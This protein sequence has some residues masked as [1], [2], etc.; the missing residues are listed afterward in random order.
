MTELQLDPPIYPPQRSAADDRSPADRTP[1]DRSIVLVETVLTPTPIAVNEAHLETILHLALRPGQQVAALYVHCIGDLSLDLATRFGVVRAIAELPDA[2]GELLQVALDH[3]HHVALRSLAAWYA[4][5]R[6]ATAALLSA[7]LA[8]D[9]PQQMAI[10]ICQALCDT[11]APQSDG[12]QTSLLRA[13]AAAA[14]DGPL[15]RAALAALAAHGTAA[16]VPALRVL[17]GG[18]AQR[19]LGSAIPADLLDRKPNDALADDRLPAAFAHSLRANLARA[20]T[21]A[22]GASNVREFLQMESTLVQEAA[23]RAL[24]AIGG[25]AAQRALFDVLEHDEA[26]LATEAAIAALGAV[27]APQGI[28]TLLSIAQLSDRVRYHALRYLGLHAD[29]ELL[30]EMLSRP[31]PHDDVVGVMLESIVGQD[32]PLLAVAN[33]VAERTRPRDVREQAIALL[34]RLAEPATEVPLLRVATDPREPA[35]LRG[36]AAAALPPQIGEQTRRTLRALARDEQPAAVRAGSLRALARAGDRPSLSMLLHACLDTQTDVARAGVAG[37]LALRDAS[38][39]PALRRLATSVQAPLIVRLEAAGALVRLGVDA[40][41]VF[42]RPFLDH[43]SGELQMLAIEQLGIAPTVELAALLADRSRPLPVRLRLIELIAR[44]QNV[45]PT[46]MKLV[47]QTDEEPRLRALALSAIEVD[48]DL[49][50]LL[51]SAAIQ[52]GPPAVRL[53]AIAAIARGDAATSMPALIAVIERAQRP[54]PM[55][56][57]ALQAFLVLERQQQVCQ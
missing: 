55:T 17:L 18:A 8:G 50:P 33:V 35:S 6:G 51:L 16:S 13:I 37:L 57:A 44:R 20:L 43:Q 36:L 54:D 39:T 52:D 12:L 49:R 38:V 15:T 26:A 53:A 30:R 34:G 46:L 22:D 24:A 14:N 11:R 5:D 41:R 23:A 9:L 48:D 7:W 10:V 32:V 29:Q 21:P 3:R 56:A 27:A 40:L 42:L 4:V 31:F 28:A 25:E 1:A 45:A 19:R 2:A 47:V